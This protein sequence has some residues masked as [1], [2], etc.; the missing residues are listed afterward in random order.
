MWCQNIREQTKSTK[1]RINLTQVPTSELKRQNTYDIVFLKEND[2][3]LWQGQ[4]K[5]EFLDRPKQTELAKHIHGKL[6]GVNS[7]V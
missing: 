7:T 3:S 2:I 6:K 1:R 4:N 5:N